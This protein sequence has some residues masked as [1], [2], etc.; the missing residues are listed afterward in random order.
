MGPGALSPC[1]EPAWAHP[2]LPLS[3]DWPVLCCGTVPSVQQVTVSPSHTALSRD[4]MARSLPRSCRGTAE[5]V[6]PHDPCRWGVGLHPGAGAVP[7]GSC[8]RPTPSALAVKG[9][10]GVVLACAPGRP[11]S[12]GRGWAAQL[13]RN[14][15]IRRASPREQPP[16][17][18]CVDRTRRAG[19]PVPREAHVCL[20]CAN[21]PLPPV[22]QSCRA[23]LLGEGLTCPVCLVKHVPGAGHVPTPARA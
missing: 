15:R 17:G 2:C 23:A 1:T 9:T 20:V 16:C 10:V 19:Q 11:E 18:C 7:G 12:G 3:G 22:G 21:K 4:V 14:K 6:G 13:P 5:P 8:A